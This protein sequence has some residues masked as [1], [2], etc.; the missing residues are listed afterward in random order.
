[1]MFAVAESMLYGREI[2]PRLLGIIDLA[3]N[4]QPIRIAKIAGLAPDSF[5]LIPSSGIT[6]PLSTVTVTPP[7]HPEIG[8][9]LSLEKAN[10]PPPK[11]TGR[12]CER[13]R[14]DSSNGQRLCIY[15]YSQ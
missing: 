1:M 11:K 5:L 10:C 13:E 14:N 3:V 9:G 7:T 8:S 15:D 12:K 2:P 6:L 4:Y